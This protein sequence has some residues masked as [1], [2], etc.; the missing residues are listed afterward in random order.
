M[1]TPTKPDI[2][3]YLNSIKNAVFGEEVRGSIHDAIKAVN[4]F[5]DEFYTDAQEQAEAAAG[6]ATQAAGSAT[7]A[8][9]SAQAAA[10]SA[11]DAQTAAETFRNTIVDDLTHTDRDK[12]LSANQGKILNDKVDNAVTDLATKQDDLGLYIENGY[13]CQS[14]SS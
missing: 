1:S 2:T 5:A 8:A 3:P 7:N 13:I 6:S 11:S 4:D 10:A 9:A 12:A 14:I